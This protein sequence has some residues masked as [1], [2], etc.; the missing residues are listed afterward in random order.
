MEIPPG[1]LGDRTFDDAFDDLAD[2]PEFAVAGG[3]AAP[4]P[5]LLEGY[6]FV[7]V[8]APAD[9]PLVALEPMT[10]PVNTFESDRTLLAEPGSAYSANFEI[11]VGV[12][13]G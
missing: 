6:P 13:A 1:P 8:W 9:S 7:Q 10:A 11:G 4:K 3:R 12:S 5:A 2:P